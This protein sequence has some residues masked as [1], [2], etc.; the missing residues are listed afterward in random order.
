MPISPFPLNI[1]SSIT[2]NVHSSFHLQARMEIRD[3]CRW[4][5]Y[6]SEAFLANFPANQSIVLDEKSPYDVRIMQ[7]LPNGQQREIVPDRPPGPR[8]PDQRI[9]TVITSDRSPPFSSTRVSIIWVVI[10]GVC[11]FLFVIAFIA[12]VFYMNSRNSRRISEMMQDH[13]QA[14]N[15]YNTPFYTNH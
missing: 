1:S 11:L 7:T 13:Q 14:Y 9:V 12:T 4:A 2:N 5:V 3:G 15:A 6:A 10:M 8:R